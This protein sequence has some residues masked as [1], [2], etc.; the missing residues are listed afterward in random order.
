MQVI[1]E[2]HLE[3]SLIYADHLTAAAYLKK[4][5]HNVPKI[6]IGNC[7]PKVQQTF[8]PIFGLKEIATGTSSTTRRTNIPIRWIS[9]R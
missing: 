5:L 2:F 4:A 9:I 8:V 1:S 3:I 6:A 7:I